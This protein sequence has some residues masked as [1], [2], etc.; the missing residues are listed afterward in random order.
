METVVM[1]TAVIDYVKVAAYLGAALAIG[2]GTLGPAL[3]QGMVG[4]KACESMGKNPEAIG[5]IRQ[6]ML[7]A[8]VALETLA[9][10][11]LLIA[12]VLALVVAR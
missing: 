8:L 12:L 7:I 6:A 2:L 4:A 3:G 1:E 10:Y 5:S 11:A 9:I